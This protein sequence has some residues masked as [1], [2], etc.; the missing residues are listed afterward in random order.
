MTSR[1]RTFDVDLPIITM[2]Y[3]PFRSV[4]YF[5]KSRS[6]MYLFAYVCSYF[7]IIVIINTSA[8]TNVE[9]IPT[10]QLL[11][12]SMNNSMLYYI[13]AVVNASQYVQYINDF[14]M[15]YTLGAGDNTTDRYGNVFHNREVK[16]GYSFFYR[17]FSAS[18]TPKVVTLQSISFT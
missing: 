11:E 13:A 3:G 4:T 2:K 7:Y 9:N 1:G 6:L 15:K 10:H 8:I 18:S 14:T 16:A 5:K 12:H 17:L